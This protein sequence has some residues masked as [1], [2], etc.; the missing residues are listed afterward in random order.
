MAA[1]YEIGEIIMTGFNNRCEI[2]GYFH[3][4]Y[5]AQK[6]FQ[7]FMELNDLGLPLAYFVSEGLCEVSDDGVRYINET[8]SLFLAYLELEDT[9]FSNLEGVFLAAGRD[10]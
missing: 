8:Y 5:S 1:D 7:D 6:E 10:L 4:H 2:L 9:G 3:S